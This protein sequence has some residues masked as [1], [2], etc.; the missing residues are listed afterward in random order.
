MSANNYTLIVEN[1]PQVTAQESSLK[2]LNFKNGKL[3][4]TSSGTPV[5][6]CVNTGCVKLT[7]TKSMRGTYSPVWYIGAMEPSLMDLTNSRTYSYIQYCAS[8]SECG[9][10][11]YVFEAT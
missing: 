2:L 3:L 9:I 8:G 10:S 5:V 1:L 4:V 6:G 7:Y 11:G